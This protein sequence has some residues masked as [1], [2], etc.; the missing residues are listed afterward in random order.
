MNLKESFRYQNYLEH[1][2]NMA[3]MQLGNAKNVT[4]VTQHHLRSKSNPEAEDETIEV[5]VE[6]RYSCTNN[7]LIDFLMKVITERRSVALAI[8]DAK[9]LSVFPC[10]AAI[11]TNRA[12]QTAAKMLTEM[13][14]RKSSE[15]MTRGTAFKFNAEG[16]Q[17]PY[18]YDIKE[19][20]CIDYDRAKAKQCAKSLYEIA[21][22]V[23]NKADL[24]L[25]ET[26]VRHTP[27]FNVNESFEDAINTFVQQEYVE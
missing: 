4:R 25:L 20:T 10:D 18:S 27:Y 5:E 23:S 2:S 16:N 7:Q 26:S 19:V 22:D 1:L 17:V 21:D 9:S 12:L 24:F 14:N 3:L 13:G 8:H 6:R 11:S 15:K